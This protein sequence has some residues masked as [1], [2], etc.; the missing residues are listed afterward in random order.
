M[1]QAQEVDAQRRFRNVS[2][3]TLDLPVCFAG[4]NVERLL[5][6]TVTTTGWS[7]ATDD[8]GE[9]RAPYFPKVLSLLPFF[10]PAKK[11]S[12]P[13]GRVPAC[14]ARPPQTLDTRRD[15]PQSSKAAS[16]QAKPASTPR[17]Q[18]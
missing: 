11:G 12:R 18:A 13:R 3:L 16:Q 9:N 2:G 10:A 4:T 5:R 15:P 8:H 17:I 1:A 14:N 7:A 6:E